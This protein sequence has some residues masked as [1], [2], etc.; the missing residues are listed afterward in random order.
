M[1]GQPISARQK[2]DRWSSAVSRAGWAAAVALSAVAVY[3]YG[4][5]CASVGALWRDEANSVNLVS[6]ASLAEVWDNSR[7]DSFPMLWFMI[8]RGW[9]AAGLGGD[10]GLRV[11][12]FLTAMASL[13]ALWLACRRFGVKHPLLSL[14]MFA[15]NAEVIRRGA[16]VR[17]YGLGGALILLTF[18]LMWDAVARPSRR[19]VVWAGLAA[20]ASVQT[21]YYGSVMLPAFCVSAGAMAA[22]RRQWRRM[23]IPAAIGVSAGLSMLPYLQTFARLGQWNSLAKTPMN[24]GMWHQSLREA[25]GVMAEPQT[26]AGAGLPTIGAAGGYMVFVWLGLVVATLVA[27]VMGGAGP[28]SRQREEPRPPS[29]RLY[30]AVSLTVGTVAYFFFLRAV[31]YYPNPW[32]YYAWMGL[33]ALCGDVVLGSLET[34]WPRLPLRAACATAVAAALVV[35]VWRAVRVPHTNADAIAAV[36]NRRTSEKDLVIVNPWTHGIAFGRYYHGPAPWATLPPIDARMHRYDHVLAAMQSPRGATPLL[37][38]A[39]QSLREGGQVWVV[40]GLQFPPRG[41]GPQPL[42]PATGDP[43]TWRAG[44]Q[45]F[46][47]LQLGDVLQTYAQEVREVEVCGQGVHPFERCR[48]YVARGF[49]QP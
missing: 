18:A 38:Q 3:L 35:P 12:G 36:L 20:V 40:G 43:N 28:R 27:A 45:T 44:Y 21:L 22:W 42:P 25:M 26:A 2:P 15:M 37:L 39:V 8:L 11:L 10:A 13:G 19:R 14:A 24:W 1:N 41:Y 34:R 6:M 30:A 5:H 9:C 33:A 47:T 17:A 4:L 7:F 29:P 46:W 48:V 31:G 32:Y 16:S 23:L 49:A